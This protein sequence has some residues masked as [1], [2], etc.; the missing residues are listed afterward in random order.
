MD[1]TAITLCMETNSP[2]SLNLWDDTARRTFCWQKS[3]NAG[4][5]PA[6]QTKSPQRKISKTEQPQNSRGVQD[7]FD[8]RQLRE[9]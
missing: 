6:L 5:R 4:Y 1:T 8:Y 7:K 3:W 2:S 9:L